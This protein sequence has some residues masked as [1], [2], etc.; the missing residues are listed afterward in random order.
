MAEELGRDAWLQWRKNGIGSSDAAVVH[1]ESKW[2]TI[3]KLYH[4]KTTAEI[5]EENSFIM[6]KGNEYEP[7]ARQLFSAQ[8]NLINGTEEKF[9]A[10]RFVSADLPILQASLDGMSFS[11]EDIAEF[12]YQGKEAHD[13]MMD[14]TLPVKGG[15]VPLYYWIQCQHQL[16]VTGAKRCHFVSYNP[17]FDKYSVNV[18]IV[19]P[20]ENFFRDHIQACTKFW[21]HVIDRNPPELSAR[22]Y[23]KVRVK[24]AKALGQKYLEAAKLYETARFN[25]KA[26][27]TE[28]IALSP[29]D[30]FRVGGL[31]VTKI[32][33]TAKADPSVYYKIEEDPWEKQ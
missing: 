23:K 10:R 27:E 17:A 22:D 28:V 12:K 6:D 19:E 13:R 33:D 14:L 31:L 24:D 15:R 16:L 4:S 8:Y 26:V 1:G 7:M 30:R 21:Q 2:S 18:V 3:A 9:E 32:I 5:E 25:L 29:H 20:D 11:C